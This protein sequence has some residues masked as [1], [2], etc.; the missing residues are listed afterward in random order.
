MQK[1][2]DRMTKISTDVPT[3]FEEAA[4]LVFSIHCCLHLIGES[5]SIGRLDQMLEPFRGQ[6]PDD[7]AQE[8]IDCFF[9]KLGERVCVNKTTLVDRNTWGTC[10]VPFRSDGMFPNGDTINQWVQQVTIGG[11]KSRDK[12]TSA[13]NKVTL[14]CLKAAKRLPLNAP[15]VSLRVHHGMDKVYLEESAKSLLSGGAH[16]IILQDDRFVEG[17]VDVLK[18][19]KSKIEDGELEQMNDIA[20]DGCFEVLIAG[21]TEFSFAYIPLPHVLEMAINQGSTY[22]SAG[23]A[24]LNGMPQSLPSKHPSE[25]ETFQE[26]LDL[27]KEHFEIKTQQ[28]LFGLLSN[29]GNLAS[30]C[31]SPFLSTLIEG[32]LESKRDLTNGGAKYK[33]ISV[34]HIGFSNAVDSL[35]AIKRLCFDQDN[36][37]LSLSEMVT[38][39]KNDWGYD[40]HEPTYDRAAGQIRKERKTDV[41]QHVRDQALKFPKFGTKEAANEP[42]IVAIAD[43]L[44]NC[45]ANTLKKLTSTEKESG[46][47]LALLLKRLEAKYTKGKHKFEIL[48]TP[49]AGTFEGYVGWGQS[50]GASADGRRRGNPIASDMSAAPSP[51]DLPP[52]PGHTTEL[53]T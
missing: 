51:Q 52:I 35:Y 48:F 7:E 4:Q 28:A 3:T 9:V 32:C 50:C 17:L 42:A 13:C 18:T 23:P 12:Q 1:I 37:M 45:A 26:V 47:P 31:P 24:Y 30:V 34:M 21:S 15:C 53:Y 2:S 44:A 22:S 29:Y 36:A 46:S 20:C 41:Y 8:I 38:C 19:Y 49:G 39:L 14:L 5:T 10:A 33:M 16:P 6:I 27:F 25:I 43:F 40:V 11:Y